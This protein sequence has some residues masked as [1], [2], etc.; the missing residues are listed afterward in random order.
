MTLGTIVISRL[1]ESEKEFAFKKRLKLFTYLRIANCG[2]TDSPPS[3]Y[4]KLVE[5]REKSRISIG[6]RAHVHQFKV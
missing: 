2:D 3:Q 1:V 4:H 5:P 6:I